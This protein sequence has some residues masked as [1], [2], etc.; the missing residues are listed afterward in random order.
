MEQ[1][2]PQPGEKGQYGYVRQAEEKQKRSN[3][4]KKGKTEDEYRAPE[5]YNISS[6]IGI[7]VPGPG[8][9]PPGIHPTGLG[10]PTFHPS[11]ASLRHLA[12]VG[13]PYAGILPTPSVP[14]DN[15]TTRNSPIEEELE[16]EEWAVRI[17]NE[18]PPTWGKRKA[19]DEDSDAQN[20]RVRLQWVFY[21]P[22][23]YKH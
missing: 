13:N 11:M 12:V 17:G 8:Q 19:Q 7:P 3:K 18:S 9:L 20:K 22:S 15:S 5:E 14:L 10:V 6:M 1:K 16:D 23:K 4:K 2:K 21:S